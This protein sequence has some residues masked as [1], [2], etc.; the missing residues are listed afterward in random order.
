[1]R[2]QWVKNVFISILI[3]SKMII[4]SCFDQKSANQYKWTFQKM[5]TIGWSKL[6]IENGKPPNHTSHSK[7]CQH[8]G[9]GRS[10]QILEV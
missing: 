6:S 2:D 7:R 3:L 8:V 1:M 5:P 10:D 9:R 4:N